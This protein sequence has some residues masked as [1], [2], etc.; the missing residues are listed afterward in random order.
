MNNN[1]RV[2]MGRQQPIGGNPSN[3]AQAQAQ[4]NYNPFSLLVGAAAKFS[5][6]INAQNNNMASLYSY[7]PSRT[8]YAALIGLEDN[9]GEEQIKKQA[10]IEGAHVANNIINL[11]MMRKQNNPM[12]LA[13]KSALARFRS[14][15]RNGPK[16]STLENFV[17]DVENNQAL[18]NFI[19]S[20]VGI[21]F[22]SYLAWQLMSG[23][24]QV[25]SQQAIQD[26]LYHAS[27]DILTL[28][29]IDY[30]SNSPQEFYK[31]SALAK[32]AFAE[33]EEPTYQQVVA[34]CMFSDTE[35]R[36]SK[37]KMGNI[38]EGTIS[39]NPLLDVAEPSNMGMGGSIFDVNNI[40]QQNNIGSNDFAAWVS[41]KAA[42]NRQHDIYNGCPPQ[43]NNLNTMVY[44]NY[45]KPKL[46][47]EDITFENRMQFNLSEFGAPLGQTG[48]WILHRYHLDYIT[49][50][51]R[52]QDGSSYSMRDTNVLGK[53]AI[54]TFD[55]EQGTFDYRFINYSLSDPMEMNDLI[56]DPSKLLPL[57]Y[58]EDGVQKTTWD[59]KVME[60][61]EFI[62]EGYILPME[63][64]KE[65]K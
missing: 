17:N 3:P 14:V 5:G 40:H 11:C 50:A 19:L 10:L 30:L 28:Q 53:L 64:M 26:I 2:M 20:Q 52:K 43:R 55:W 41:Q 38:A 21:Q 35:C 59:P 62:R 57:M 13:W 29:F 12:Y 42:Q 60:T 51:F 47:I 37:G 6:G 33:R 15:E 56:S 45:D 4:S 7:G 18:H 31:M 44:D 27:I 61:S 9:I 32:K 48:Y 24:D 23:N 1:T 46:K 8:N 63:E 58:E 16:E 54:W 25:R 22:G 49:K 39:H 34:R 65:L 36:Y